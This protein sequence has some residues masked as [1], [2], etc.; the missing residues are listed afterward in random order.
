MIWVI[1]WS[2]AAA[3]IFWWNHFYKPFLGV[4]FTDRLI[5]FPLN[6]GWLC[7]AVAVYCLARWLVRRR[8]S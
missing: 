1:V 3:A 6:G 8:K 4:R 2:A 5:G 7:L